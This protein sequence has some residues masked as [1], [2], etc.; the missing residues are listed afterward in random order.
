[1]SEKCAAGFYPFDVLE[2]F[3]QSEMRRVRLYA[4]AIKDEHVQTL[5]SGY[6]FFRNEVQVRRV[7]EV[8]KTICDH[9]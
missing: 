8:V 9:R 5:Q 4:H 6:R 7:C 3:I 2:R 1:M